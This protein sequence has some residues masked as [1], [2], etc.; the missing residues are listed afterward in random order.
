MCI[1]LTL[2][3]LA[4]ALA[5]VSGVPGLLLGRRSSFGE[6]VAAGMMGGAMATGLLGVLMALFDATPATWTF[7]WP[8]TGERVSVV[9]DALSAFFLAPVFLIGGLGPIYGLAYWRQVDHP[10]NGRKVRLFW[11]L[12]AAGMALLIV[13]RHAM[14]FL[15][16][17]EVMALSAFFL[18]S[19]ED[20]RDECRRAGRIYLMATHAGTLAL[21]ALF[22]L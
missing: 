6:R 15:V 3:L 5:A 14:L 22:V 11:G 12:M 1:S 19:A 20:H 4:T 8:L 10:D 17:W 7:C 21:F 16:G 9:V 18:V 2:I 13:A